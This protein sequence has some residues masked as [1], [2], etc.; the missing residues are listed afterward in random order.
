MSSSLGNIIKKEIKELLTPS[1]LIPIIIFAVIFGSLAA[2][3][4]VPPRS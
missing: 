2:C 1:T 3:S 4:A